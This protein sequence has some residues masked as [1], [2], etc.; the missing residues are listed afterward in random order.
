MSTSF[1]AGAESA[2]GL[3]FDAAALRDRVCEAALVRPGDLA[4]DASASSVCLTQGLLAR[5]V[6]TLAVAPSQGPLEHLKAQFGA[7]NSMDF[8]QG[9]LGAL[10]IEDASLDA[11]L[12]DRALL[13]TER[14]AAAVAEMAAKLKPGGRLVLTELDRRTCGCP[15]GGRQAQDAG[16]SRAEVARWLR[17]AGLN[18]ESVEDAGV[19][20]CV[21]AGRPD[22]PQGASMFLA[23]GFRPVEGRSDA[24]DAHPRAQELFQ[25]GWFCAES[26]LMAMARELGVEDAAIPAIST[27]FCGGYARTSGPCGAV[28]GALMGVGLIHG[29]TDPKGPA[30][31]AYTLAKRFTDA[32]SNIYGSIYCTEILGGSLGDP[33]QREA[34]MGGG[35]LQRTCPTL[36]GRAASLA[37]R[38][39]REYE[40]EP[41]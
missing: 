31:A 28:S 40:K 17:E 23:R 19:S 26:V 25:S 10:P 22:G 33:Q 20:C 30:E 11:I 6:K 1:S 38:L 36:C 32:F 9:A 21:E 35:V 41:A 27:C 16:F 34:V 15:D 13:G 3:T 7:N 24:Y 29:R 39:L 2:N 18:G 37:L 4:A 14:P 5:G 8:R 12:A